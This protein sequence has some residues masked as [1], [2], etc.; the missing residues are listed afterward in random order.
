MEGDTDRALQFIY[1]DYSSTYD[2]L[3]EK[4]KLPSLKIRRIRN[5]GIGTFNNQQAESSPFT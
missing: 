1:N 3:L 2:D 5:I 4:S